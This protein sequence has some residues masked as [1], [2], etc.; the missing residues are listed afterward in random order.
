LIGERTAQIARPSSV[1]SLLESAD[2]RFDETG[3]AFYV[4]HFLGVTE[5]IQRQSRAAGEFADS[6]M[7]AAG[8]G[9][10]LKIERKRAEKIIKRKIVKRQEEAGA[11]DSS[12]KTPFADTI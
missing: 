2:R 7:G 10:T 9:A 11:M 6:E 5:S 3:E 1:P 4:D 12:L 8:V